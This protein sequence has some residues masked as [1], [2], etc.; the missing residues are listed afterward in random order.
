MFKITRSGRKNNDF[1][2]FGHLPAQFVRR[3][4]RWG[5]FS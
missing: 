5:Y 3:N 2:S 1:V 4:V